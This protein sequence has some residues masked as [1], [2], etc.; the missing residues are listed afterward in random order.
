[1]HVPKGACFAC[2]RAF[3][4]ILNCINSNQPGEVETWH[5]LLRLASSVLGSHREQAADVTWPT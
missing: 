3:E 4:G 1:M 2:S 5:R